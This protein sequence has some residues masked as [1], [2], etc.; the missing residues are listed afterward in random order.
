MIVMMDYKPQ[1]PFDVR[2]Q[3][4]KHTNTNVKGVNVE[5]YTEDF[6]AWCSLIQYGTNEI[7][8]TDLKANQ[9]SWSFESYYSSKIKAGDRIKILKTGEIYDIVGTP[10]NVRMRNMYIKFKMVLTNG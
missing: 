10:E 7:N 9:N 2:F 3:L 6:K 5:S 4:L 8:F 1:G